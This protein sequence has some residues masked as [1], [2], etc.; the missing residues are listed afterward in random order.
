MPD[1]DSQAGADLVS[2]AERK[3]SGAIGAASARVMIASVVKGEEISLEGVMKI[4]DE[5]SQV[6]EYSHRLE[7]KSRELVL[8][9]SELKAANRRLQELDRLKDEFV[10]TVTHELRTPLTSVRAFSEILR[11]NPELELAERQK[12]LAIIV[13]ESERLTRLINQVLDLAK[14]ESGNIEWTEECVDLAALIDEALNAL[15]Q[16]FRDKAINLQKTLPPKPAVVRADRD[17]LI[18]VLINLLSNAVKFCEPGTGVV[19]IRLKIM[20]EKVRVEVAD[21]GPGI[22]TDEQ[23][24]IFDKFHQ[25]KGLH[26]EKPR[27]SGLGLTICHRII[28]HHQGRIWIES[29]PGAGATFIFELALAVDDECQGTAAGEGA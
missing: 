26:G 20:G 12:F 23:E 1:N 18:Q 10:S 4:L 13:K 11:D 6:I 16:L 8:T 3:L 28:S 29:S 24:R 14:I 21:N 22:D 25:L 19:A 7:E 27:G 17:R 2:F 15:G 9:T 5:T